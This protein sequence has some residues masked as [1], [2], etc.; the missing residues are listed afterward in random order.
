MR[1]DPDFTRLFRLP[2]ILDYSSLTPSLP[3]QTTDFDGSFF[4]TEQKV[5][6]DSIITRQWKTS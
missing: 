5:T 3:T 6:S 2:T 4:I 1:D